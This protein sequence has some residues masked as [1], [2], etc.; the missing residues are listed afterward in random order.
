MLFFIIAVVAAFVLTFVLTL[1]LLLWLHYAALMVLLLTVLLLLLVLPCVGAIV[2][3][4]TTDVTVILEDY[5]S[6]CHFCNYLPPENF[7]GLARDP[8]VGWGGLHGAGYCGT[9]RG[10]G[11]MACAFG[12]SIQWLDGAF[13]GSVRRLGLRKRSLN[14]L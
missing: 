13:T 9:I 6:F 2:I 3:R 5:C 7:Y 1:V 12:S 14:D 4:A 11:S 10:G 8:G